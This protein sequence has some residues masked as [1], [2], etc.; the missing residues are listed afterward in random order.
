MQAMSFFNNRA[1]AWTP[2]E[3]ALLSQAGHIP[4]VTAV[5]NRKKSLQ[6]THW[7]EQSP[8]IFM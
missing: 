3:N 5:R 4:V 1:M 8:H 7:I 2:V 6:V